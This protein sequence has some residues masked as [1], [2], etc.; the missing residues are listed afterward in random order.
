MCEDLDG[1]T[2]I[3]DVPAT[4][5]IRPADTPWAAPTPTS[6]RERTF[7]HMST[8]PTLLWIGCGSCSGESM[9]V[10][11][12]DGQATDFLDL[13]EKDGV[14]LLWHPSLSLEPLGP[15]VYE[16]LKEALPLTLLCVEGSIAMGPDGTGLFDTFGGKP[17]RDLVYEL[18]STADYVLALGT[19]ACYGGIPAAAPNPTE[20]VG[21]Q[22]ADGQLGGLLGEGW[23][24]RKGLPVV[25]VAGCAADC[26]TML[27]TMRWL[28]AG[29]PNPA[30]LDHFGRPTM[31]RPC[32]SSAERPKCGTAQ[33]VGH[34]CYGCTSQ[35]FPLSRELLR[36]KEA[37]RWSGGESLSI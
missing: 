24:S 6:L 28:L 10:L 11:G 34:S 13:I 16:I 8:T 7:N 27:S 35:T 17:K 21:L 26:D 12:V 19:C 14:R 15:I 4:G 32:L 37:K 2:G 23:R 33:R 25:N 18:C 5:R 22:Y 20:A 31:V 36:W 9:A 30:Q 29:N 1:S 3:L